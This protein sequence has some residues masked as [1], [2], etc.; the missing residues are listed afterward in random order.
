M[1]KKN[2]NFGIQVPQ[3]VIEELRLDKKNGNHIWK[4]GIAKEINAVMI[5][6]KILDEGEEPPPTYQDIIFHMIFDIKMED[7]RRKAQYVA[8]G[9]A[10]V[11]PPTLTYVSVVL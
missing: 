6:L 10:T 4:D 11:L 5:L 3:T 2:I 9:H 7:F 1:I 8:V